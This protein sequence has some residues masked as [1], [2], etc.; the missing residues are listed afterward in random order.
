MVII[1]EHVEDEFL[2]RVISVFMMLSSS[3]MPMAMLLFGPLA[4]SIP[5]ER[6]LIITGALMAVLV[7]IVPINRTLMKAGDAPDPEVRTE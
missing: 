6:M 4:E 2:G 7:L 3:L 5:I 1:Q